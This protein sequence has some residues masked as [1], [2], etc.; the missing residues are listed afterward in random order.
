MLEHI[1]KHTG[2]K[3]LT[4]SNEETEK[5]LSD[6]FKAILGALNYSKDQNRAQHFIKDYVLTQMTG[7][8]ILDIWEPK[9]SYEYIT[10]LLNEKPRLCNEC[11]S[12]TILTCY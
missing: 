3:D 6:T 1:A 7:K 9:E 12:N 2:L 10:S 4:L 11:A 5:T 8:E